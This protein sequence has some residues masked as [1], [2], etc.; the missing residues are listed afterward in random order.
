[1]VEIVSARTPEQLEGIRTLIREFAD[2]AL[3]TFH[4]GKEGVPTVFA[5]LDDELTSL[6]GKYAEP[7][8]AL[9]LA[10]VEGEIAGCLGGFRRDERSIEVTRLWVR[11]AS[12]GHSVGEHLV[13]H[14]IV[15]A[16][17]TNYDRAVLRS[18]KAMTSAHK[19]YRS[20]GF[21]EMDGNTCFPNFV[22]IEIAMECDLRR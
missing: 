6:P 19:I 13:R 22:D 15:N 17:K 12:R 4:K 9:Y 8:G 1:M 21:S 3:E 10:S 14:F 2:W 7:D 18:L 11:P 20:A 16:R 5:T